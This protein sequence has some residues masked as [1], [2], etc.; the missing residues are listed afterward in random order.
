M[1]KLRGTLEITQFNPLLLHSGYLG[2]Y[3]VLVHVSQNTTFLT[4]L[5]NKTENGPNGD[6]FQQTYGNVCM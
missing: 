5:S 4:S 6:F 2:R 3:D 1:S